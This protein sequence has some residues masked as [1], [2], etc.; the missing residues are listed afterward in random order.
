MPRT[1]VTE[2][3]DIIYSQVVC[4]NVRKLEVYVEMATGGP[5]PAAVDIDKV[6]E[7]VF[8]LWNVIKS[9]PEISQEQKNRIKALYDGV[10]QSLRKRNGT[11]EPRRVASRTCR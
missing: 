5:P 11:A 7:D 10:V 2:G 9:Q 6:Q 3:S 4:E 1:E 8:K